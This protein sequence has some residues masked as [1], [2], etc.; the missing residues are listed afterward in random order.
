MDAKINSRWTKL[1]EEFLIDQIRS[2]CCLWD[3]NNEMYM[4]KVLNTTMNVF[5][6]VWLILDGQDTMKY[7][8]ANACRDVGVMSVY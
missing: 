8:E 5:L 3:H 2:H 6:Q 4:K 1:S 7:R